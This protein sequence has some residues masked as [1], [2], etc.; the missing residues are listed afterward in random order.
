MNLNQHSDIYFCSCTPLYL[1]AVLVHFLASIH[2]ERTRVIR[3]GVSLLSV[4]QEILQELIRA[5]AS[6]VDV[7]KLRY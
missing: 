1:I 5:M 2:A 4:S 3:I 7:H 6:V